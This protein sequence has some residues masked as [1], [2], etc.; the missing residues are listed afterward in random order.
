MID[1]ELTEFET[2]ISIFRIIILGIRNKELFLLLAI[3]FIDC[4]AIEEIII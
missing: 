3:G 4:L 2:M 1:T